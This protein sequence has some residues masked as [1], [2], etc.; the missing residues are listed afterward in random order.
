MAPMPV[1][2]SIIADSATPKQGR[3]ISDEI[4]QR[5]RMAPRVQQIADDGDQPDADHRLGGRA[6][7]RRR[8]RRSPGRTSGPTARR[9]TA[10]VRC[11]SNR[12]RGGSRTSSTNRRDQH[13]AEHA[14]RHVDVEDPAPGE[15]GDDEAADRRPEHRPEQRRHGQ[16]RHR[17]HQFGLRRGAQQHEPPDRHHHRPADA[18]QH[19]RATRNAR[20]SARPHRI[21]P[22]V[23]TAI[24][25]R[26]TVRVPIAVGDPAA[27]RE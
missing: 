18:L 25:A 23:N 15:I 26:N 16:P 27:R 20:L 5:R 7:A 11:T 3:R 14:D 24:A 22:T 6:A 13:D 10:A 1:R 2:N 17:R 19:A 4:E 12:P 8:G 21:E 9:R